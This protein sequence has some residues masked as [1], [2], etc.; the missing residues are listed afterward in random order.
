[1]ARARRGSVAAWRCRRAAARGAPRACGWGGRA[2]TRVAARPRGCRRERRARARTA[3]RR[4]ETYSWRSMSTLGCQRWPVSS[5]S[6][7]ARNCSRWSWSWQTKS[8][9]GG[10]S[11][12][13]EWAC[14]ATTSTGRCRSGGTCRSSCRRGGCGR[15]R[16]GTVGVPVC[17]RLARSRARRR[18]AAGRARGSRRPSADQ[19]SSRR[20]CAVAGFGGWFDVG[21]AV[22]GEE[23]GAERR[24]GRR[25]PRR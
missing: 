13:G 18:V 19:S 17:R 16:R 4:R 25:A 11:A 21:L 7:A 24:G 20:S 1:M 2:E 23:R 14:G 6:A 15:T 10:S 9:N 8:T 12:V 22:P 5:W 3:S